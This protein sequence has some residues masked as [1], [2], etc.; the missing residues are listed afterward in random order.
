MILVD[1]YIPSLNK[2]YDFK[3]DENAY[4]ANIVEEIGG[5]MVTIANDTDRQKIKELILCDYTTNRILP[6]DSTLKHCQITN[7]SRLVL[8]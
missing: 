6:M 4:I 7:G 1:V 5:M 8:V 2:Q 3:L